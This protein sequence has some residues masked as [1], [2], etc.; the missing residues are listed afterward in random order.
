MKLDVLKEK[1]ANAGLD[2]VK[3]IEQ[4][5]PLR[6]A[7][8]TCFYGCSQGCFEACNS[9]CASGCSYDFMSKM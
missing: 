6:C 5:S 8:G 3:K 1:I 9:G 2:S 4:G 7:E